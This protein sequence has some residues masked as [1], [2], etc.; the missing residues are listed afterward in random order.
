MATHCVSQPSFLCR[1]VLSSLRYIS[2]LTYPS[3]TTHSP[4]GRP[5]NDPHSFLNAT[6]SDPNTIPAGQA[7]TGTAVFPPSTAQCNI[8]WL[9]G[10]TPWGVEQPCTS[11]TTYSTWTVTLTEPTEGVGSGTSN[12]GLQFKLVDYVHLVG[13]EVTKVYEGGDE[14]SV[15]SGLSGSCGGSGVCNWGLSSKPY[16]IQQTQTE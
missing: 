5:G 14:F 8:Q 11:S 6:I 3:L 1:F 16:A 9:S 12:F 4:S 13:Y 2:R 10:E 7:P 15:G